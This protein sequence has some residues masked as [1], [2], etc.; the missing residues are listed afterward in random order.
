MSS[1]TIG[2]PASVNLAAQL[3][4]GGDEHR[5]RVHERDLGVDGALGVELGGDFRADRQVADEHVGLGLAQRRD[6]VNRLLVGLGDDL[7]VVLAKAVKRVAALHGHPGGGH[8]RELDRVVLAGEDRVGEVDANLLGVHVEGGDHLDV[9]HVVV[10]EPHVHEARHAGIVSSVLVVLK[11]LD[12][13]AR[14]VAHPHDGD[15]HFIGRHSTHQDDSFSLPR[16]VNST[17]GVGI[18][19]LGP[20]GPG[21][22]ARPPAACLRPPFLGDQLIQP[23][24]I[25]LHGLEP[26]P[27]QFERVAVH[28]LAGARERRPQPFHPVLEAAPPAL[29]D[30]Q[31]D[32]CPGLA[33]EREVD[34]EL[35][36]FPGRRA[37]VDELVL[38][39]LLALGGQP[40]DDLRPAGRTARPAVRR[41]RLVALLGDQALGVQLVQAGVQ[42]AVGE[43][44]ERAEQHVQLLAELVAVHGRS[45]E[46]PENGE[47]KDGSPVAAHGV[48]PVG[49]VC[50]YLD[51]IS[52]RYLGSIYR[53]ERSQHRRLFPGRQP[54]V[55]LR[56][57]SRPGLRT[58]TR[59]RRGCRRTLRYM[60]ASPLVVRCGLRA[61]PARHARVRAARAHHAS[62]T[63]ATRTRT[64]CG[65]PSTTASRPRTAARSAVRRTSHMSPMCTETNSDSTRDGS[66]G[67][68]N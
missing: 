47:L 8:V 58:T 26:V 18:F 7:P 41:R 37:R 20:V 66:S 61:R 63:S 68:L 38:E 23:A 16:T 48:P 2:T 28:P 13:R 46:Q 44:A 25:A 5:Q 36:V 21:I 56:G 15:A 4:V 43:R 12:E 53:V 65:R 32:V 24:D 42:G 17:N 34:A 60:A 51:D 14:A 33:E 10:A 27:L 54:A 9:R 19:Y 50:T 67:V 55:H 49:R 64:C 35:V 30:P 52:R 22:G 1:P 39:P 57:R 6:D 31:P 40:V 45:M 29:Q 62:P 59:I 3:R 11:A